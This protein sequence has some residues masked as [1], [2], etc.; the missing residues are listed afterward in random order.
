M[1]GREATLFVDK[2]YRMDPEFED[3]LP[4]GTDL[5]DGMIVLLEDSLLKA[6]LDIMHRSKYEADHARETNQW[7]VVSDVEITTRVDEHGREMQPLVSF[8]A[9]YPDGH[10]RKRAYAASYAWIVKRESDGAVR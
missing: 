6:D 1:S 5:R 7:C 8:V 9:I 2:F 4:R 3:L 10:K